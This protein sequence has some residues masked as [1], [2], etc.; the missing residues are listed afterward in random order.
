VWQGR[1]GVQRE[2]ELIFKREFIKASAKKTKQISPK[3]LLQIIVSE[4]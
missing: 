3:G 4:P 1:R 2:L